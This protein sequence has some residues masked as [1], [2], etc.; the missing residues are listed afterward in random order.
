[1]ANEMSWKECLEQGIITKTVPDEERSTQM[2][3][4]AKL[5]LQFWGALQ[6]IV[7]DEYATLFVEAYYDIIKEL[8]FSHLYMRQTINSFFINR[9][10]LLSLLGVHSN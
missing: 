10:L 6:S 3:K 8:I 5:R 9:K 7:R 1:M 2:L 4:V